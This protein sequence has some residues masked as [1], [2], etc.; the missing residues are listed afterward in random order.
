L[1]RDEPGETSGT[2]VANSH[3]NHVISKKKIREFLEAHPEHA[4]SRSALMSWYKNALR[5]EWANFASVRET[6]N[7]ADQVG[8]LVVFNIAGNKIRLVAKIRY[9][10]KPRVIYIRALLTHVEYDEYDF[11]G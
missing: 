9:N 1:P 2:V 3:K 4:R 6:F 11:G 5:A 10:L 7:S 8:D